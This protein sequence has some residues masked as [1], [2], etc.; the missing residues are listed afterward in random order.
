M[1]LEAPPTIALAPTGW[2]PSCHTLVSDSIL[3]VGLNLPLLLVCFVIIVA[4]ISLLKRRFYKKAFF[5]GLAIFIILLLLRAL[6]LFY[7]DRVLEN[8]VMDFLKILATPWS[9][10]R[11]LIYPREILCL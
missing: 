8:P 7:T 9:M 4:L 6:P 10:G 3:F 2:P 5:I 11:F 1:P